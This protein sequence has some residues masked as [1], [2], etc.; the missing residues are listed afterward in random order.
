M[1]I[2]SELVLRPVKYLKQFTVF[3]VKV[4]VCG[5]WCP[6]AVVNP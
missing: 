5:A 6:P 1:A 2:M 3:I 4:A